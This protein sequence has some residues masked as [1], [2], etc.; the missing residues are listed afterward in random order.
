[1]ADGQVACSTV[2][3]PETSQRVRKRKE[4]KGER[5]KL[6]CFVVERCP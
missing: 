1:M 4:K 6:L 2:T 5:V 3:V